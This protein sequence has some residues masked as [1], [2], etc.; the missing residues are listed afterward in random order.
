MAVFQIEVAHVAM[1][2]A[3]VQDDFERLVSQYLST[4]I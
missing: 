2:H 3:G 4:P 1:R